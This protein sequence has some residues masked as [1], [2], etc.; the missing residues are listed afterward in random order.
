MSKGVDFSLTT[1]LDILRMKRL[2]I[3]AADLDNDGDEDLIMGTNISYSDLAFINIGSGIFED[4]TTNR[5]PLQGLSTR[6]LILADIDNDGDVDIFRTGDGYARN[7]IYINTINVPDSVSPHLKNASVLPQSVQDPGPY[8]MKLAVKD[9]GSLGY[10]L[11]TSLFYSI[12]SLNY[13]EIVLHYVGGYMF[14]GEIPEVDSGT[15][16][17]YYYSVVDKEGNISSFPE[18]YP[19]TVLTFTYLPINTSINDSGYALLPNEFKASAYPNPFNSS[20]TITINSR[21]GG[22]S[23]ANIFDV[24]GR[25][26]RILNMRQVSNSEQIVNWDG[27]TASNEK[28]PSGIYF[29]LFRNAGIEKN[30]KITHIR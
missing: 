3:K 30:L 27:T 2:E 26:I 14:Y 6:S 20:I 8:T 12:D 21:K 5:L 1:G 18:D 23:E 13:S 11:T 16:I 28:V 19:D 17:N 15:T 29:V 24:N 4:Q 25:L 22:E 9:G 10:Q 7:S